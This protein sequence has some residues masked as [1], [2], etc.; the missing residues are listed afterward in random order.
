[1]NVL[2]AVCYSWQMQYKPESRNIF[3]TKQYFTTQH[4]L[5]RCHMLS[6]SVFNCW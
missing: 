1:M 5:F 6:A 2:R 4:V 3:H